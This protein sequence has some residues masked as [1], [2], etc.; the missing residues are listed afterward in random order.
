M[1]NN[2]Y[3]SNSQA[4]INANMHNECIEIA[5]LNFTYYGSET[6]ALKNINIDIKQGEFVVI[7]G[8]SGCGKSTLAMAIAGYIK[9]GT[10]GELQGRIDINEKNVSHC[11]IEQLAG[12][13]GIVLQDPE[14]QLCTF[15]VREEIAFGPENL[16]L[17]EKDIISRIDVASKRVGIERLLDNDINQLSGGE[18]QRVAIA[19][20][21]AME[22]TILILDEPTANLDPNGAR[23][24]LLTLQ[25]I[26]QTTKHTIIVIEHRIEQFL[27]LA[28]R[29]VLMEKGQIVYDGL[30]TAGYAYYQHLFNKTD[31]KVKES[32]YAHKKY[33][34]QK[35]E[36]NTADML[37][38]MNVN[39]DI[40]QKRILSDISF[41]IKAGELVA[42]MG[43]NGCGK[44]SLFLS[45]LGIYQ[46]RTGNIV[47]DG[48]DLNGI[49][50]EQ[51]AK[52]IGLTFQNPNHQ[53]FEK[54]VYQ[55]M[56]L[57]YSFLRDNPVDDELISQLLKELSLDG[58]KDIPPYNL[59]L[60]E[61][62]RLILG[63]VMAY[64]P[65]LLLLD[66]PMAGQDKQHVDFLMQMLFKH[67]NQ[68]KV[69]MVACHQPQVVFEYFD[70]V[71]FF[72]DGK[73]LYD[74]KPLLV[75][76]L[77]TENGYSGYDSRC[78]HNEW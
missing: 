25:K 37:Q 33:L 28:D 72:D 5:N 65:K 17:S 30:P 44:T 34:K 63:E 42:V 52:D 7:T 76:E 4:N 19:A 41:N 12:Q 67:C 21:L 56:I 62:K 46:T 77:L 22:P 43:R 45:L 47:L 73:L 74:G 35:L 39:I 75:F 3:M 60:G 23:D 9:D 51:R 8:M 20:M 36:E 68:G 2:T 55:E 69:C 10:Q 6:P 59:S 11:H 70:R 13:V 78:G 71:L 27:S 40:D 15:S 50:T 1:G 29:I 49:V 26:K 66:E 38:V 58:Y 16:C 57:P 14:A 54:S 32:L 31:K 48:K 53:I 24:V 18:K 61:K 64:N